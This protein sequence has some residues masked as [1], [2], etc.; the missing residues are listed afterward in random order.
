MKKVLK[1]TSL[2]LVVLFSLGVFTSCVQ[3]PTEEP[4]TTEKATETEKQTQAP[5]TTEEEII[6]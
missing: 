3:K 6:F 5:E 1:I 2:L 4:T